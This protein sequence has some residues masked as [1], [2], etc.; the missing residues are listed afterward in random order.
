M[1]EAAAALLW[2]SSGSSSTVLPFSKFVL[3]EDA[4][5][6]LNHLRRC[7][8]QPQNPN[9]TRLRLE[10]AE[11]AISVDLLT[12][13]TPVQGGYVFRSCLISRSA[14]G[15]LF[16]LESVSQLVPDLLHNPLVAVN[17]Q[18]EIVWSNS[19]FRR[20]F[21][22]PTMEQSCCITSLRGI[23]WAGAEFA[24]K[25]ETAFSGKAKA[26]VL[27][28][29]CGM[30]HR[31]G[32]MLTLSIIF[33]RLRL[34]AS[35]ETLVLIEMQNVTERLRAE[36]SRDLLLEETERMSQQLEGRVR[37]RTKELSIANNRLQD[38]SSAMI[39][40]QERERRRLAVELHDEVGQGLTALNLMLAEV[41]RHSSSGQEK[42]LAEARLALA[43]VAEQVRMLS[44]SLRPQVLDDFGLITALKW[45]FEQFKKLTRLPLSFS[46]NVGSRFHVEPTIALTIYRVTQEALNNIAKHAAAKK[47]QVRLNCSKS[48]YLLNIKDDGRGFSVDML[49]T[50]STGLSGMRERVRLLGGEIHIESAPGNGTRIQCSIPARGGDGC[51]RKTT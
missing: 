6:F 10:V 41:S 34:A 39:D 37:L 21:G 31:A 20:F 51:M 18:A 3:P 48:K 29:D 49:A 11:Q 46:T 12:F 43:R 17:R 19:A 38:L 13:G 32:A 50:A 35:E 22:A 25:L 7:R 2:Q 42:P 45:H 36:A 9:L 47:V 15:S 4:E 1:N 24:Q 26:Q 16:H 30:H 8:S 5:L 14:K 40:A 44:L 27:L 23:Q 28:A 33:R